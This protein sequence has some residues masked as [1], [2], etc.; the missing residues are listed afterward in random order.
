MPFVFD[1]L[2]RNN[3][4]IRIFAFYEN[5]TAMQIT[6]VFLRVRG[7]GGPRLCLESLIGLTEGQMFEILAQVNKS[8]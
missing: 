6:N 7:G 5:E 8:R 3:Q 2:L 4:P 1:S